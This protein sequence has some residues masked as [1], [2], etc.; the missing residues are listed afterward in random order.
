MSWDHLLD[1]LTW[2][3]GIATRDQLVVD[4][5]TLRQAVEGGAVRRV[6]RGRYAL[7]SVAEARVRAAAVGGV[8]S[9]VSAAV[10]YGWPVARGPMA[11]HVTVPRGRRVR[12]T[13]GVVIHRGTVQA[14]EWEAGRTDPIRTVLDCSRVAPF[15]QA[16]AVADS[17]LRCGS[18]SDEQLVRAAAQARGPGVPAA[19]RVAGCA[20]AAAANPFESGAR[21]IAIDVPLL[22]VQPQVVIEGPGLW[23]RVDLADLR[24]GLVLECDGYEF[25]SGPDR[26]A[27]DRRRYTGLARLDWVVFAYVWQDVFQAAEQTTAE[28]S[29]WVARQAALFPADRYPGGR[30]GFWSRTH[31]VP[32]DIQCP[33]G[34]GYVA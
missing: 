6:S 2:L 9:H 33:R 14:G 1:Q 29:D 32:N 20:S 18:V 24:W 19:R 16:L 22:T 17:A 3:G 30:P 25:H 11:T 10:D 21:A 31:R 12:A 27:R 28:L 4:K 7:P 5:R 8:L 23:A 15:G 13:P 26:F 34:D